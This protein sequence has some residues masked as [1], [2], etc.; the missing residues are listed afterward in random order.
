MKRTITFKN[1]TMQGSDKN[2]HVDIAMELKEQN[3]K[4][5]FSCSAILRKPWQTT[6]FIMGGQ[7]LDTIKE[8]TSLKDDPLFNNIF[9]MWKKYHLNDMHAGT[10]KQEAAIK[11]ARQDGT[12]QSYDYD[13]VK[14]YLKSINL[15][16]DESYEHNGKAYAYGT[17]WLYEEIPP[18]DLE[19]IKKLMSQ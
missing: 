8:I 5:T 18:N 12:L 3:E 6:N 4:T 10:P 16:Y 13:V 9:D 2:L 11:K 15:Y 7:C 14:S 17:G 19:K 1:V